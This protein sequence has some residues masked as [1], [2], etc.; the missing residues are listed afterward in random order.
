MP[1][2]KK[3]KFPNPNRVS[4]ATLSNGNRGQR[5][6][7]LQKNL[8]YIFQEEVTLDS[9]FGVNV[10][11]LLYRLQEEYNIPR[12]GMYDEKTEALIRELT[13]E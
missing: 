4:K 2:K 8:A 12:T 9:Q 13:K 5:V 6:L 3:P 10:R 11:N 7:M 1:R